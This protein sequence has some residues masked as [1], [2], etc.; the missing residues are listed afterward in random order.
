MTGAPD[1]RDGTFPG[2]TSS[3]GTARVYA[4]DPGRPFADALAAGILDHVGR[5]PLALSGCIVLMPTRRACR[6][7]REAFLRLSG[8]E[9]LLLP[10]LAPLGQLDA[11]ELDLMSTALPGGGDL[12]LPPAF[13]PLRRQLLLTKLVQGTGLTPTPAQ[14]ARLAAEL[15]RLR[16][17]MLAEGIGLDRLAGLVPDDHALHWQITLDFLK[18]IGEHWPAI[19]AEEGAID[20]SARHNLLMRRQAE[21]WRARPPTEP[22]IAVADPGSSRGT[23]ELLAVVARLPQGAVVLPGLD[24]GLDDGAWSALDDAHPQFGL[25]RMMD[26]LGVGR[27][28]VRPWPCPG[29]PATPP[30]RPRLL[31]EALRPAATTEAWRE[32]SGF[33]E[34]DLDGLWR[35]DCPTPQEEAASIALLMRQALETPERTAALVTPDRALARRV[36]MALERWGIAV[37]DSGGRPLSDTAVGTF[38]RLVSDCALRNAEPVAL[39]TLLKHPLAAGGRDPA[40]FRSRARA[41]ERAVL[42]GPRPG[43]GFAGLRAA[44]EA[45]EDRRFARRDARRELLGWVEGLES[46]TEPWRAALADGAPRP[47]ATWLKLHGELAEALAATDHE[48]GPQRLWRHEDGEAAA[49]FLNDLLRAAGDF[50]DVAGTDYPALFEALLAAAAPVRPRYGRHPRLSILGLLEARLQ[51]ADVIVL[52]GLNEGTWPPEPAADPW[53]SRPMRKALGLASPEFRLGLAAHD[54]AML[55]CAPRVVLTRA[56]RVDGTPTVP[57][58][59]LLRLDAVLDGLGLGGIIGTGA[60]TWLYWAAELDRPARVRPV[61]PPEPRPPVAARPRRLSVTQVETWMRDPYAVYARHVLGLSALDPIAADPGAAERGQFIHL[62]LDAFVREHPGALPPDAVRRLLALGEQAFGDHLAQ[63][64][65][66][67]FWWPRFERVAR[68]FVAQEQ[69]RRETTRPLLTEASG[70]MELAGPAGPFTLVAKADRIDLM[71]DGSLA[72]LD[73][74][75]G[76]PPST[77]EVELG[78]APQLPL[79]AAIAEAGGFEPIEARQVSSLAFW[80]L[81]GGD[82]P[83]EEKA[84]PP[85][86]LPRL[87]AEARAGLLA[88]IHAFDDPRTPYR[89]LPRPE[90]A[91]RYSDYAHLARVQEW[92]TAGGDG[93]E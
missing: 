64:D 45:A 20:A 28:E 93:G 49:G 63:P 58:R 35:I 78:F 85:D 21:L 88:L 55:A 43:A 57:S 61:G 44:L 5:D 47:L 41:L 84:L 50:G 53:L 32:L 24:L 17:Q 14:A 91:P 3:D 23:A 22:V 38:L 39:L 42:R 77:R 2:G 56:E 27:A 72:I 34:G 74:K 82:P 73:Y 9:P 66:W 81:S 69:A 89:A 12:D 11:D 65:V 70:R 6:A 62:A 48:I 59:W 90:R 86:A 8:G 87:V 92:S 37:D 80:R 75:T 25:S 60:E 51:Q 67:A 19:E 33:S 83:G 16:D 54:F 18:I 40:A 15:A 13:T 31:G 46:L 52:G 29:I 1:P 30:A 79:E 68:W 7:L 10:R 76:A 26:A 36:A 71:P 4:V